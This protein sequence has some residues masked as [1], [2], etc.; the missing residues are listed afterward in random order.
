M[1]DK[2][3]IGISILSIIISL[4]ATYRTRNIDNLIERADDLDKRVDRLINKK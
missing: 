4:A 3:M 2:I 1:I